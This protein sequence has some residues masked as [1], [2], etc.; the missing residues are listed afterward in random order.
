MVMV[1]MVVVSIVVGGCNGAGL[2]T[3]R[4]AIWN[5]FKGDDGVLGE[6]DLAT[7]NLFEREDVITGV[8]FNDGH[9]V[10]LYFTYFCLT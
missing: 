9:F 5:N 2:I 1:E 3:L 6:N 7:F 10:C 4:S 8:G